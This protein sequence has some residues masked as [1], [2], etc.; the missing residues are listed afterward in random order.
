MNVK[1][2]EQMKNEI[3]YLILNQETKRNLHRTKLRKK[4]KKR[5]RNV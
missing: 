5:E 2:R 1:K 3:M 4:K